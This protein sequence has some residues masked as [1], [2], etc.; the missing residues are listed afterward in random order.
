[1]ART[2]HH[3][4]LSL[5]RL[6]PDRPP[7]GS[8]LRSVVVHDLRYSAREL[9]DA[10]RESRRPRPR[11]IRRQVDFRSFPRHTHDPSVARWSAQEERRA[12]QRLRSRLGASLRLVNSPTGLAR[13]AA[14]TVD[15]PPTR[16]RRG[17]LWLA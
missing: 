16:H 17:S 5:N 10:V 14:E 12:R 1:M 2:A 13:H 8:P 11:A 7:G 15:I 4:P 6:T 9:A 3:L